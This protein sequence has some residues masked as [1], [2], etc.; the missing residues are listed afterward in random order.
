MITIGIDPHKSSLTAVAVDSSGEPVATVQVAV[1][2]TTV[3]QLQEWAK[4]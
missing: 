2:V 1:A 4:C 3:G